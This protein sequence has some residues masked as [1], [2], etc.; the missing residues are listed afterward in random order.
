MTETMWKRKERT[1][2]EQFKPL[3]EAARNDEK[4]PHGLTLSEQKA[5]VCLRQIYQQYRNGLIGVECAK[6]DKEKILREL[7]LER[8]KEAFFSRECTDLCERIATAKKNYRENPTIENA[9][10]LYAAFC[11]V[12]DD[13]RKIG[14]RLEKG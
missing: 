14:E 12:S 8:S 7:V 6:S 9:D 3:I 13:W 5:F 11:R 10:R 1:M 4:M 2:Y